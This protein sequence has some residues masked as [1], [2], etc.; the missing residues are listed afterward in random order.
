MSQSELAGGPTALEYGEGKFFPG[1][2]IQ[3]VCIF[4]CIE[5]SHAV[6]GVCAAAGEG[7]EYLTSVFDNAGAFIYG[8]PV[9][10]PGVF[11]MGQADSRGAQRPGVGELCNE[12]VRDIVCF[13]RPKKIMFSFMFKMCMVKR[14]IRESNIAFYLSNHRA[15]LL[16]GPG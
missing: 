8:E 13:L 4:I 11:R 7:Q 1:G 5:E 2:S 15:F 12:N 6:Q 10:L 14:K 3:K 16:P 9:Q